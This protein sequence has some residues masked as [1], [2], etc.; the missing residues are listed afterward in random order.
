MGE[1]SRVV[2]K[3]IVRRLLVSIPVLIAASF[4]CFALTTA[5]GDPLGEWKLQRPRT[6]AEIAYAEKRAGLDKPFLARYGDWVTNFVKGDWGTTVTPGNSTQD[7]KAKVTKASWVSI[8]L[9]L[10]AEIIALVIGVLVGVLGAV[11]Q[12]SMFD[13]VAT[14]VAFT[15]FSMPMFCIAVMVKYVSIDFND[16][17]Q[18]RFGLG[19]WLRTAGPPN[20]GF[21][22]SITDQVYQYTGAYLLPTIC[23]VALQFAGYS[24]FQRASMLETMNTDYVQA[25]VAKGLSQARVLFRHAFRN[26]LIPITTLSALS[27][28]AVIAGGLIT[29]TVF[30]WQGMG[31]L[32]VDAVSKK[33]PYMLLGFLMVTAVATIVFNLIADIAYAF[34]DPRIRL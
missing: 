19:R 15:L 21:H 7:V 8:R 18:D 27:F 5:M 26:A 1:G 29:E 23:L 17:M 34:L 3:Y 33:E 9:L 2:I 31:A 12:Y 28:G 20:G 22:G 30:A 24:R 6:P 13:Y 32:L 11:R 10:G 16:V 14:G 4:L 25:A